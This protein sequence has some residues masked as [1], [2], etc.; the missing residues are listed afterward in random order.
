MF[1]QPVNSYLVLR[2]NINWQAG[3]IDQM[4]IEQSSLP[5][6]LAASLWQD[7]RAAAGNQ[8]LST[9]NATYL[10]L[11]NLFVETIAECAESSES[12]MPALAMD[13]LTSLSDTII[14]ASN[15]LSVKVIRNGFIGNQIQQKH[16]WP[17]S[18]LKR[19]IHIQDKLTDSCTGDR[20][21]MSYGHLNQN[22]PIDRIALRIMHN[23]GSPTSINW[24]DNGAGISVGMFQANQKLGELPA[25]IKNMEQVDPHLFAQIFGQSFAWLVRNNTQE[26]RKIAFAN[27]QGTGPNELGAKLEEAINQPVFQQVQLAM[28]LSKIV[29]AKHV[30]A[31]YGITSEKGVGLVADMINQLGE[32]TDKR[33]GKASGARENLQYALMWDVEANKIKAVVAHSCKAYGR[34]RRNQEILADRSL[35]DERAMPG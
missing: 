16:K 13:D 19:T 30:A 2:E 22:D 8:K 7:M 34:A 10:V 12:S 26:L 25:L 9:L 35:S 21:A 4:T 23:E 15:R 5:S 27:P 32:G 3:N 1:T 11:T 18:R 14:Q 17:K 20:F 33:T 28:L 24:S 31:E 29:H 6:S